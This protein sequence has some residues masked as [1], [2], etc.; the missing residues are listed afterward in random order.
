MDDGELG[1]AY[2]GHTKLMISGR[3]RL[4]GMRAL[5]AGTCAA[6]L[7]LAGA[8]PASAASVTEV[9][10][11]SWSPWQACSTNTSAN[12]AAVRAI[13]RTADGT[14]WLGGSFSQLR[15]PDGSQSIARSNL[16]ALRPDGTPVTEVRGHSFNGTVF[17]LATDGSSVFAGGTFTK[18]DGL[19]ALRMARFDA[20]TGNRLPFSSGINGPVYASTFSAGRLYVGG[21]FTSVQGSARGNLAALDPSSGALD[22][23]WRPS[24][25]LNVNDVAPNDAAHNN[26]PIRSIAAAPEGNRIYVAGDMDVLNGVA[27]PAIGAVDPVSGSTESSFAPPTSV[28]KSFQGFQVA[29][30]AATSSRTAGIL[31]AAGGLTNR[32]F[33]FGLDGSLKWVVN[34]DGDVQAVA[35]IGNTVYFGGHFTCV[36]TISCYDDATTTDADRMHIAAFDYNAISNP[37]ADPDWVP[38]LGPRWNPYYYGVWTLEAFEGVLHAGGVFNSVIVNGSTTP[39]PKFVRFGGP[40]PEPEPEPAPA[41]AD[42]MVF[43]ED[44]SSG[45]FGAWNSVGGGFTVAEQVATGVTPGKIATASKSLDQ[46]YTG[47]QYTVRV[48]ARSLDSGKRVVLGRVVRTGSPANVISI[49]VNPNGNLGYR[50]EVA[51]VDRNSAVPLGTGWHTVSLS[52]NIQG[53]DSSVAVSVDDTP[54]PALTRTESLGTT[55]LSS[56]QLGDSAGNKAYTVDYDDVQV[57]ALP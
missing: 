50:N 37:V 43:S 57:M 40:P 5:V 30:A 35:A 48:Q 25:E 46:E 33:H 54:V 15:S 7:V 21:R 41:P 9:P 29:T 38:S 53:V 44:F 27:R 32:A 3:L 4:R 18:V 12:C 13:T 1:R 28:N 2:E 45:T 6:L 24:V 36:S 52:V 49:Y 10:T 56:V 20:G 42:N 17:T 19:G 55:G 51:G 39:Q 31:L 16:A 11:T 26:T 23:T 14:V 47:L 22:P 34:T 8:S